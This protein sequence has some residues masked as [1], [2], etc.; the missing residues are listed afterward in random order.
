MKKRNANPKQ[1][2]GSDARCFQVRCNQRRP[3]CDFLIRR[4]DFKARF[5]HPKAPGVLP[6]RPTLASCR[7]RLQPQCLREAIYIFI[8]SPSS[9]LC[10][11]RTLHRHG[12]PT[13]EETPTAKQLSTWA[14]VLAGS[15]YNLFL[16]AKD[17]EKEKR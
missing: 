3:K 6:S 17:H 14:L 8:P 9:A 2:M 5:E 1:Y 7:Y 15:R 12:A 13:T 11:I 10:W 16:R 4:H